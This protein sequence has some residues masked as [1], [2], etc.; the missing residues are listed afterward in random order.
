MPTENEHENIETTEKDLKFSVKTNDMLSTI[1]YVT[2]FQV[3][4]ALLCEAVGINTK[5]SPVKNRSV[6]GHMPRN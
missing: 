5:I 2:P 6:S 4:S 3:L 1:V